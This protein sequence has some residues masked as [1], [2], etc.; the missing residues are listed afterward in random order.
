MVSSSNIGGFGTYFINATHSIEIE[1]AEACLMLAE[2]VVFSAEIE[3]LNAN[4][5]LSESVSVEN[6]FTYSPAHSFFEGKVKNPTSCIQTLFCKIVSLTLKQEQHEQIRAAK[7]LKAYEAFVISDL[8]VGYDEK[9]ETNFL[10]RL[11]TVFLDKR[12]NFSTE[13]DFVRKGLVKGSGN[14]YAITKS[15]IA[16]IKIGIDGDLVDPILRKG[17]NTITFEK[18]VNERYLQ[19]LQYF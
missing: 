5:E 17:I 11:L 4:R 19:L 3:D 14:R 13:F 10:E 12:G 7:L 15:K 9:Q 8:S 1:A 6:Q 2:V 18:V 16:H